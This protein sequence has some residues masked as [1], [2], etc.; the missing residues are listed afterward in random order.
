MIGA[1]INI[2]SSPNILNYPTIYF[3]KIN[4]EINK[5]IIFYEFIKNFF[6]NYELIQESSLS[7]IIEEF[8]KRLENLGKMITIEIDNQKIGDGRPGKQSLRLRKIYIKESMKNA[9]H[10]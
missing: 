5:N 2:V 1:G 9:L 3:K 8:K 10:A 4:K 7:I 6:N